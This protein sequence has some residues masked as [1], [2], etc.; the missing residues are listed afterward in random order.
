MTNFSLRTSARGRKWTPNVDN[1]ICMHAMSQLI[2]PQISILCKI[3]QTNGQGGT[4]TCVKGKLIAPCFL[5][6]LGSK[7]CMFNICSKNFKLR[8]FTNNL[9]G[10]MNLITPLTLV[11]LITNVFFFSVWIVFSVMN[12]RTYINTK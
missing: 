7:Y 2:L 5:I 3:V 11:K 8:Y 12:E 9:E 4:P 6:F 10:F 1:V